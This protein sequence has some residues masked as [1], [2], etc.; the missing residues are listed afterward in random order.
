[1]VLLRHGSVLGWRPFF[2]VLLSLCGFGLS[3]CIN[4]PAPE[5]REF[6]KCIWVS[7]WEFKTQADLDT[8][9]KKC[10][11]AGFDTVFLQVRGNGTVHYPSRQEIWSDNYEHKSP[12]F[13]PLSYAVVAAHAHG[14]K[15]HAWINMGPGWSGDK[16]P[17]SS[18][19]LFRSRPEWFLRNADGK[20]TKEGAYSWL[21]LCLPEVR[22]YLIG[23]CDEVASG[24]GVDGIHLDY[25]RFPAGSD[26]KVSPR[27][28]RSVALFTRQTSRPVGDAEAFRRWKTGCITEIVSGVRRRLQR[29]S[30]RVL[31]ST[32]V[33]ADM[34]VSEEETMQNWPLWGRKGFVDAVIPMNYTDDE[35]LFKNRCQELIMAAGDTPVVMGIG[36]Y[37]HQMS[38]LSARATMRQMDAAMRAGAAGV[39]LFSYGHSM[40]GQWADA[41]SYW[42]RTRKL[43]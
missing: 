16:P 7:R 23:I 10:A 19:Q 1:M 42:N 4:G 12:G 33:T 30:R 28:P 21:N 20:L 25:I 3:G 36:V 40:K 43:R 15:L 2:L 32:A 37:K 29:L 9:I 18:R 8:I 27:D 5:A 13:D 24:Y 39:C 34:V 26:S 22:S 14:L 41:M 31:L 17:A 35:G 38:K 11:G 6:G